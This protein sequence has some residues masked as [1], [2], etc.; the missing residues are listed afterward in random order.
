MRERR[1]AKRA[2]TRSAQLLSSAGSGEQ[3]ASGLPVKVERIAAESPLGNVLEPEL[4]GLVIS[5][6]SLVAYTVVV[7]TS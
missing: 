3:T 4:F 6:S 5:V 2:R 1:A 7:L